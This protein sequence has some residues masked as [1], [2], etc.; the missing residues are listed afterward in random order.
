MLPGMEHWPEAIWEDIIRCSQVLF[1]LKKSIGFLAPSGIQACTLMQECA[2]GQICVN[3][4][5]SQSNVAI[6]GSQVAQGPTSK[7]GYHRVDNKTSSMRDW[8]N[9]PHRPILHGRRMHPE[10]LF[11][12]FRYVF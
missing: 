5:C 7:F 2:N 10:L 6:S 4:Y 9:L 11:D 1:F 12:N 8:R 3:G